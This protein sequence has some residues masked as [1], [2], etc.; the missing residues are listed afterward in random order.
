M[1]ERDPMENLVKQGEL[2][3]YYHNDFWQCMDTLRDK[4][5]LENLIKAGNA[6]WLNL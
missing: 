2:M 6:P 4:E 3:A 1:L 5:Y